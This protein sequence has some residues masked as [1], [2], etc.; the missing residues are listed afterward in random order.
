MGCEYKIMA[1]QASAL[2]ITL[3]ISQET[4]LDELMA[5]LCL[6]QDAI[7]AARQQAQNEGHLVDFTVHEGE[8]EPTEGGPRDS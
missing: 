5:H 4:N 7:P 6:M 2:K 3:E 8:L 1:I